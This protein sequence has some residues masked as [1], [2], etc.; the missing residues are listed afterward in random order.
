MLGAK[1]LLA[2]T[3]RARGL[4]PEALGELDAAL[5]VAEEPGLLFPRRQAMA[6]RAGTLL[7]LGRVE[8]ALAA[9]RQAVATPSEDVR[10]QV[11]ALRANL[12]SAVGDVPF[13]LTVAADADGRT[14]GTFAA[15]AG[16]GA[17]WWLVDRT[18]RVVARGGQLGP[19]AFAALVA[20]AGGAGA[21]P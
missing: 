18:G 21:R 9:A 16:Q 3:L 7:E 1:V 12:R 15:S 5:A 8:E 2:Q 20:N 17:G 14:T 6:H 19:D 11:L 4:L 13:A 10:S